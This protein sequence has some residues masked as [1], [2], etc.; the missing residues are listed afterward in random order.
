M[1]VQIE[2]KSC[3]ILLRMENMSM[4][5]NKKEGGAK[6]RGGCFVSPSFSMMKDKFIS[7]LSKAGIHLDQ[8][9]DEKVTQQ[10]FPY[11]IGG[12]YKI[13]IQFDLLFDQRA[14]IW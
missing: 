6:E 10:M 3:D 14:A 2:G 12:L 1:G 4:K 11:G 13:R 9:E 8:I 5:R 7:R